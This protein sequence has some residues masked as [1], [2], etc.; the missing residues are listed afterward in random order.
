MRR[1]AFALGAVA[2]LALAACGRSDPTP[3]RVGAPRWDRLTAA[4]IA[5][6]MS[7]GGAL[8]LESVTPVPAAGDQHAL[9]GRRL[10][11]LARDLPD[12]MIQLL[13]TDRTWRETYRTL[14]AGA[15][16]DAPPST[17]STYV[18]LTAG[19]IGVVLAAPASTGMAYEAMMPTDDAEQFVVVT[20]VSPVTGAL[21]GRAPMKWTAALAGAVDELL[22]AP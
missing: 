4:A 13:H 17:V 19:R 3:G 8:Q 2:A 1:A 11:A 7:Y 21:Q 18:K 12:V 9:E 20:T 15:R 10:T 6:K 22:F 14:A 5:Q 16:G